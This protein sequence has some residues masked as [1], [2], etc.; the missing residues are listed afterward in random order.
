MFSVKEKN[1]EEHKL[2]GIAA[3][4]KITFVIQ[5]NDRFD[6]RPRFN[7][8]SRFDPRPFSLQLP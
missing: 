3:F 8:K 6:S 5:V 7:N 2:I 4:H 1:A